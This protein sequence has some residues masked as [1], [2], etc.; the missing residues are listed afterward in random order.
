MMGQATSRTAIMMSQS[1]I[2]RLALM[3]S[4]LTSLITLLQNAGLPLVFAAVD[5]P[6]KPTTAPPRAGLSHKEM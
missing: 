3:F 5:H 2:L 4:R 6:Y 1:T